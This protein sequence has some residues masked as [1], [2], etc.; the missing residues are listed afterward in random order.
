M[1]ANLHNNL[2]ASARNLRSLVL[3]L[4]LLEIQLDILLGIH[5]KK[6]IYKFKLGLTS[7]RIRLTVRCRS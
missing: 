6:N 4:L 5:N 7:F 3:Q 1:L 2:T